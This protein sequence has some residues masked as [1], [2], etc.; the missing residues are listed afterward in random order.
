MRKVL[1]GG[2]LFDLIGGFPTGGQWSATR[3]TH[4]VYLNL[5]SIVGGGLDAIEDK[6]EAEKSNDNSWVERSCYIENVEGSSKLGQIRSVV[7]HGP[8]MSRAQG[9]IRTSE[10]NQRAAQRPKK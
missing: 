6:K 3:A 10:K 7:E 8:S 4:C 9:E 2:G 5:V 1:D